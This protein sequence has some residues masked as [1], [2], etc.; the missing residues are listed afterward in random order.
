MQFVYKIQRLTQAEN[1]FN[2]YSMEH[3]SIYLYESVGKWVR[4]INVR[5]IR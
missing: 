5:M 4:P 2:N 1:S 3:L